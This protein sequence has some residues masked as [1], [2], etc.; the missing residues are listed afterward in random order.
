[1]PTIFTHAFVGGALG[2]CRF[3][4]R[5]PR[6]VWM[7]SAV[8][9]ML[10]DAD[11]VAF[12]LGVP[13]DSMLGHRG[14]THSLAA[15]VAIG[16]C[17][18]GVCRPRAGDPTAASKTTPGPFGWWAYFTLVTAS[19]GLLDALTDGGRGIAL[20]APFSSARFY[21]PW[22]PIHVSPI[23]LRFFSARGLDVA[24]SELQWVWLPA[25]ATVGLVMWLRGRR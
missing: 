16:W 5:V 1:M 20:L 8:C 10:P 7:A 14:L 9:G 15:A 3:A 11:V 6:V 21:F 23:G 13:Y 4:G 25:V 22:R 19:H 2:R 24:L 12:S 17:A 18:A